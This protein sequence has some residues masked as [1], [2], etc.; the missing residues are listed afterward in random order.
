MASYRDE[1]PDCGGVT[2]NVGGCWSCLNPGCGWSLC[3]FILKY[4]D[5]LN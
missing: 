2:I 1:C 5:R 3:G 4:I